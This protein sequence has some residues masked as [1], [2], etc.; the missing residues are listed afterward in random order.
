MKNNKNISVIVPFYNSQE[1]IYDCLKSIFKSK[2]KKFEVIAVSDGSND[3]SVNIVK[4]FPCKLIKSTKNHGSGYARNIGAKNSKG[5]ILVFID[6]DVII[7]ENALKIINNFYLKEHNLVAQGIYDHKINYKKIA[8]QYL[9]SY[10]CYYIF[11]NKNKFIRNMVSNFLSIRKKTFYKAGCFDENFKG[12]NAEDADLGYRIQ[13]I[14]FKIS[15][16]RQLISKHKVNFGIF[17]FIKKLVRIHTGEMKMFLRNKNI[18]QKI[19]QKNY[20]PIILSIILLG[21]Q[22]CSMGL[23]IFFKN[24]YLL[25][26]FYSSSVLILFFQLNFLKFIYKSKGIT[27]VLKCIPF[28]YLHISLFFYCFFW[29]IIDFYL[30]KN[31]Y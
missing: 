22:F 6:S 2:Y 19:K 3:K 31:K 17:G 25:Y 10:Q 7:R 13:N 14:G 8:T 23:F 11:S 26:I 18:K 4:K 12:S 15:I 20:L 28:I 21:L 27:T 29:G 5:E 30:L 24:I 16:V 9:Q 1:T